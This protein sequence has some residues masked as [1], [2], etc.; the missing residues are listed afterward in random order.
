[1]DYDS[2]ANEYLSYMAEMNKVESIV[3]RSRHTGDV[4]RGEMLILAFMRR[5]GETVSPGCISREAE[6]STARVSAAL[7]SLEK[8]GL[9][10][11]TPSEY[12]RRMS[13]VSLTEEGVDYVD[14]KRREMR[15]YH[16]GL[17]GSLGEKDACELVRI[18]GRLSESS[19][20]FLKEMQENKQDGKETVGQLKGI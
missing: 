4:M 20:T 11:R 8:K 18:M 16:A 10:V 7:N 13:L 17:L 12:D 14:S 5:C 9:V 1:M 19:R 15:E 6:I 3:R 2:L